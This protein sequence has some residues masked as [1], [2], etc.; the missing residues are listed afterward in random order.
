M[1]DNTDLI[2]RYLVGEL[3]FEEKQDFERL[4]FDDSDSLE[5]KKLKG[6]MELQK[7]I[8]LAIQARGLKEN[9]RLKEEQIRFKRR[10][11]RRNIKIF[12]LSSFSFVAAAVILWAIFIFPIA[13]NMANLSIQ[14]ADQIQ[15]ESF[16]G[17]VSNDYQQQLILAYTN[18]A[19]KKFD[20]AQIIVLSIM[21]DIDSVGLIE[22]NEDFYDQAQWLNA[23]CEMN[24]GHVFRAKKMLN[25][26]ANSDSYYATQAQYMLDKLKR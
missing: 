24:S 14:Y 3:S 16:R 4:L 21:D 1:S 9:L 11:E 19:D 15:I 6:E 8:I 18:I 17:G 20:E 10:K 5:S 26:I 7:E 13:H 25:Q 12:G 2:D 23:I 22:E